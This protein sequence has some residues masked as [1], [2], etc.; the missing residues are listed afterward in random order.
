[1]QK[2]VEIKIQKIEACT[3]RTQLYEIHTI[4]AHSP[5]RR[6]LY[7][8]I[9]AHLHADVPDLPITTTTT[10]TSTAINHTNNNFFKKKIKKLKKDVLY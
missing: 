8:P 9:M 3:I 5:S 4:P 6:K 2:L 1:M 7:L 10:S